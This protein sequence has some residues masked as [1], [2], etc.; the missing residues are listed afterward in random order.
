MYTAINYE[1][2]VA[3]W[4]QLMQL[5]TFTPK[6]FSHTGQRLLKELKRCGYITVTP[7]GWRIARGTACMPKEVGPGALVAE[8]RLARPQVVS[9]RRQSHSPAHAH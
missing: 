8:S 5:P 4:R 2:R 7:E 6:A 9:R 1:E 3:I